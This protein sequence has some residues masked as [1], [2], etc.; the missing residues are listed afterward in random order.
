MKYMS[1][2]LKAYESYVQN[3]QAL[4]E[5]RSTIDRLREETRAAVMAN[6]MEQA[7]ELDNKLQNEQRRAEFFQRQVTEYEQE[8][9]YQASRKRESHESSDL[10]TR[11]IHNFLRFVT[12]D[13]SNKQEVMSSYSES[14]SALGYGDGVDKIVPKTF[15][16]EIEAKA[17]TINPLLNHIRMT[18]L[19]NLTVPAI[20][21]KSSAENN[22]MLSNDK[23][24]NAIVDLAPNSIN[25]GAFEFAVET[26]LTKTLVQTSLTE[27]QVELREQLGEEFA[28]ATLAA[29]FGTGQAHMNFFTQVSA[30]VDG[31]KN[32]VDA[33]Y[34]AYFGLKAKYRPNAKI[35]MNPITFALKILPYQDKS[36]NSKNIDFI[37]ERVVLVDDIPEDKAVVGD[38]MRYHFNFNRPLE[39]E[40]EYK[41]SPNRRYHFVLSSSYDAQF[42]QTEAFQIV[43]FAG[44]STPPA[45]AGDATKK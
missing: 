13:E 25:F 18:A 17:K 24:N 3:K 21:K 9:E 27:T 5:I 44:A 39:L 7:D 8:A 37:R 33:L 32:A 4:E 30:V 22:G 11:N 36:N 1:M 28:L 20:N 43:N 29:M 6:Q 31:S 42:R 38:F 34:K 10:E 40:S 12:A 19:P 14:R 2:S 15:L 41:A 16:N 23:S 26:E 35:A 45:P